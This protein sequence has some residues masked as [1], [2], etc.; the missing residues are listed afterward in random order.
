YIP[1]FIFPLAFVLS[2]IYP[3]LLSIGILFGLMILFQVPFTIYLLYLPLLAFSLLIFTYM[4]SIF[5]AHISVFV[6]DFANILPHLL[7][8]WMFATPIF[9]DISKVP[10]QYQFFFKINPIA[11]LTAAFRN[12]I[13]YGTSP[14]LKALFALFIFSLIGIFIGLK[15]LYKYDQ[16][17]N[18]I[19][20]Q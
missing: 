5:L 8:L 14:N 10:D 16:V 9:Y 11:I 20:R 12:V 2:G 7:T 18:R 1:K 4:C 6:S 15:I 17:Y 19:N 3:F 13:T